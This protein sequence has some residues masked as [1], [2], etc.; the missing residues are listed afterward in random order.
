VT[1]SINGGQDKAIFFDSAGYDVFTA[2]PT[3]ARMSSADLWKFDN[4]VEGFDKIYAMATKGGG[5]LA[6][7]H[8]L[9][10]IADIVTAAGEQANANHWVQLE[11]SLADYFYYIRGFKDANLHYSSS[12]D[13]ISGISSAAADWLHTFDLDP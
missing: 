9:N 8:G 2:T 6:E 11:A 4:T 7:L 10:Y 5:D 13:D 1:H 12:Q 3:S